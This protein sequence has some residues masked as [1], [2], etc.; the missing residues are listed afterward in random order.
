MSVE[1]GIDMMGGREGSDGG[2]AHL[3]PQT[4]PKKTHLHVEQS[5]RTSTE[6]WQKNLNLQKGQEILQK[7][8]EQKKKTRRVSEERM[9]V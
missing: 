8:Q 7:G 2:G 3:L 6:C 4:H 5:H 9:R 1:M